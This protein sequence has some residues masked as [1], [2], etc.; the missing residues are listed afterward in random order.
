MHP[1]HVFTELV[2]DEVVHIACVTYSFVLNELSKK[3]PSFLWF[4]RD[5]YTPLSQFGNPKFRYMGN[6]KNLHAFLGCCVRN[7]CIKPSIT[8]NCLEKTGKSVS[9][10]SCK[11]FSCWR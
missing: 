7:T 5:V 10:L 11:V 2:R 8:L 4:G 9:I 6:K 1:K 3:S